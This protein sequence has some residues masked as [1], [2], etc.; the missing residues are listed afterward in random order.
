MGVGVL[1]FMMGF[2]YLLNTKTPIIA[3]LNANENARTEPPADLPA[4]GHAAEVQVQEHQRPVAV[5][6]RAP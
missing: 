1:K 2:V 5:H 6:D 4:E 3:P